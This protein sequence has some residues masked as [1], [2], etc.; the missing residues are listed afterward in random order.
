MESAESAMF[1]EYLSN[2]SLKCLALVPKSDLH[3]HASNGGNVE[4]IKQLLNIEIEAHPEYFTSIVEMEKWAHANIKKFAKKIVRY[5]A[6]FVQAV[7]DNISTLALSFFRIEMD[8]FGS[9]EQFIQM[10]KRLKNK[11]VPETLFLPEISYMGQ[12]DVTEIDYEYSLLDEIF[13]YDYFKSID[14]CYDGLAHSTP[15]FKNFKKI[16]IKAKEAGL[17]LKAHVGEYGTADEI[18]RAVEELELDEVHHGIAAVS[19]PQIMKWLAQHKIQLNVCPTSNIMLGRAKS[20]KEHPIRELYDYGVPVTVNSDDMLIFNQ[21]VSQEY[22]NLYK[23]G[24][25]TTEELDNIRKTGLKD[26][27]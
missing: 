1:K 11:H 4:Y 16:F 8:E 2:E 17:R 14:L 20:Y 25:M 3:N 13:S 10:L 23:C 27:M 7:N 15:N 5:E 24:L 18:M 26:T 22:L 21:S 12:S 9:C 19:S 6:A